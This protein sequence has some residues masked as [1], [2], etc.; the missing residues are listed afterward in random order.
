MVGKRAG[1]PLVNPWQKFLVLHCL[2]FKNKDFDY[3][4]FLQIHKVRHNPWQVQPGCCPCPHTVAGVQLHWPSRA[5]FTYIPRYQSRATFKRSP[6]IERGRRRGREG[7]P[8]RKLSCPESE[9]TQTHTYILGGGP[10]TTKMAATPWNPP[11]PFLLGVGKT[12][13]RKRG[14]GNLGKWTRFKYSIIKWKTL[15]QLYEAQK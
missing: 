10:A 9:H 2:K 15:F 4:I 11:P 3:N 8:Q 1:V 12:V 14:P 5:R 13:K 7:A 6:P